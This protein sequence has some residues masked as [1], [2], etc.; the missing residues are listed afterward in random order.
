MAAYSLAAGGVNVGMDSMVMAAVLHNVGNYYQHT[1]NCPVTKY[2]AIIANSRRSPSA[3]V[4]HP[5]LNFLRDTAGKIGCPQNISPENL[6]QSTHRR[7]SFAHNG[8][9]RG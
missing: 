8:D 3:S 2:P 9:Y 4:A 7:H 5:P 6:S 1:R